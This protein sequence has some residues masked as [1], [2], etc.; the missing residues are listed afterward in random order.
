M[1]PVTDEYAD[2]EIPLIVSVDDHIQEPPDLWTQR[3]PKKYADVWPR[4]VYEEVEYRA[5]DGSSRKAWGDVWYYE[6]QRYAATMSSVS[7]DAPPD[8]VDWHPITYDEIRPSTFRA[9][10]RLA[11]MDEDKVEKSLCFPNQFVRFCG[12]R[13]LFGEDRELAE[14]CVRAYNDFLADEWAGPS[15]GR[16]YGA[17]IVP[18]WDPQLA[19]A[20]VRRN[21]GRPGLRAVAFSELPT[22]LGLPSL[23][24][25]EWE[26]FLQACDE[27]GTLICIHVGSSSTET[28]S[29]DDAPVGMRTLHHFSNTALSLSD[30]LLSGSLPKHPSIQLM[31]SEGQAGWMPFL[32]GRLDRKW[33]EGYEMMGLGVNL[34]ELPSTYFRNQVFACVT[35]DPAAVMFLDSFGADNIC[36]ET[37]FPHLDGSFPNS[38]RAAQ[39]QFGALSPENLHKVIRGNALKLL[40]GR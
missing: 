6:K 3:L 23:Y 4:T 30:W 32:M 12:Q 19:A 18:L 39:K 10:D 11:A 29:S 7:G 25:G 22:R 9:A 26:P 24:T 38:V 28:I 5:K 40:E 1:F 33:A 37:D 35:E 20:E 16:L 34:P 13:F 36:F 8:L 15:G 17:A 27:T 2:V 21:A 14:L 31:Y